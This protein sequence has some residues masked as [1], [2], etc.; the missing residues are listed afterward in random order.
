MPEAVAG[1]AELAGGALPEGEHLEHLGIWDLDPLEA[2]AIDAALDLADQEEA[3]EEGDEDEGDDGEGDD[4]E[5]DEGD[6]EGAAREQASGADRLNPAGTNS[7]QPA[8][9]AQAQAELLSSAAPAA[10]LAAAAQDTDSAAAALDGDAPIWRRTRAR[11]PLGHVTLDELEALLGECDDDELWPA[12]ED[13]DAAYQQFLAAVRAG[14]G[15][16]ADDEDEEDEE[17]DDFE[18][19]LDLSEFMAPEP[20]PPLTRARRASGNATGQPRAPRPLCSAQT[21]RLRPLKPATGPEVDRQAALA[22]T[23]QKGDQ[24][25]VERIQARVA[26]MA[27]GALAE[28]AGKRAAAAEAAAKADRLRAAG[29]EGRERAA[30]AMHGMLA[31]LQADTSTTMGDCLV[32]QMVPELLQQID[33]ADVAHASE[34]ADED[35]ERDIEKQPGGLS[36]DGKH[37]NA[38]R[39]ALRRL[40]DVFDTS[41]LPKGGLEPRQAGYRVAQRLFTPGEDRLLARALLRFGTN[42]ER[43]HLYLLPAR[44]VVE[45]ELRVASRAHNRTPDNIVKAAHQRVV[46][47][48][49]ADEV[50][51]VREAL[52]WIPKA[53][54][55]TFVCTH[56]LPYRQP[57]PASTRW[58]AHERAQRG[59]APPD[60]GAGAAAEGEDAAGVSAAGP[61]TKPLASAAGPRGPAA[62]AAVA[63]NDAELC[64]D[65]QLTRWTKEDDRAILRTVLVDAGG[66]PSNA[67]FERLAAELAAAPGRASGQA[68]VHA[69]AHIR[70]RFHWLA[71]RLGL[72]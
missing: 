26:L 22:A 11:Q 66:R 24:A 18:F 49:T 56:L 13:E 58:R 43:A 62:Q 45:V 48:M 39:A 41:L 38:L 16:D 63:R 70:A 40:P 59:K 52:R 37:G 29:R 67:V 9:G 14:G 42:S 47:T 55:W 65:G 7:G 21:T 3:S 6:E 61:G 36:W 64:V 50:A 46:G 10:L 31:A 54:A 27:A 15:I 8:P 20:A 34:A 35:P 69:P 2:G 33:N 32:V 4:G 28:A 72:A 5:G 53:K 23:F 17:D 57:Q 44:S 19:E 30:N 68:A 71:G 1:P 25:I 12:L 51:V 60:N